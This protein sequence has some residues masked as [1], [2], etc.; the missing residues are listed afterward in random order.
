MGIADQRSRPG[1]AESAL[2]NHPAPSGRRVYPTGSAFGSSGSGVCE[3]LSA[4]GTGSCPPAP[5]GSSHECHI[6]PGV[7]FDPCRFISRISTATFPHLQ[8]SPAVISPL[9]GC[10]PSPAAFSLHLNR[11]VFLSQTVY[12]PHSRGIPACQSHQDLSHFKCI[13]MLMQ[14]RLPHTPHSRRRNQSSLAGF[15]NYNH[16]TSF[17]FI[18]VNQSFSFRPVQV[19]TRPFPVIKPALDY[20]SSLDKSVPRLEEEEEEEKRGGRKCNFEDTVLSVW[21]GSISPCFLLPLGSSYSIP[22]LL[23]AWR[24]SLI[25]ICGGSERFPQGQSAS[26]CNHCDFQSQSQVGETHLLPQGQLGDAP[27]FLQCLSFILVVV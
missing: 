9:G 17:G 19:L 6:L 10:L 13:Y 16:Q 25:T 5:W 23:R 14:T 4:P 24:H 18:C 26:W 27:T 20:L 22:G 15:T 11:N 21:L 3:S 7:G 1:L 8:A 12:I 2:L